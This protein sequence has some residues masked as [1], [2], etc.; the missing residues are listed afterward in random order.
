MKSIKILVIALFLAVANCHSL[1]HGA[2][3]V[4]SLDSELKHKNAHGSAQPLA[5]P[6]LSLEQRREV[7][8]QK[9]LEKHYNDMDRSK[10]VLES[11]LKKYARVPL[12]LQSAEAIIKKINEEM[13]QDYEKLE[14]YYYSAAFYPKRNSINFA[15]VQRVEDAMAAYAQTL[16]D[17][18]SKAKKDKENQQLLMMP[19]PPTKPLNPEKIDTDA[20]K[21]D[22]TEMVN[23]YYK[24]LNLKSLKYDEFCVALATQYD[25]SFENDIVALRKLFIKA[26]KK[27][28]VAEF[29]RKH[30]Y[31]MQ[32]L[33]RANHMLYCQKRAQAIQ[34][35][36]ESQELSF[37]KDDQVS[38]NPADERA[39]F[40]RTCTVLRDMQNLKDY[41][42]LAPIK[43]QQKLLT[44]VATLMPKITEIYAKMSEWDGVMTVTQDAQ[45]L[46][47]RDQN[48][49]NKAKLVKALENSL[50]LAKKY[51]NKKLITFFEEQLKPLQQDQAK[52][53]SESVTS[54]QPAQVMVDKKG[55]KLVL[56]PVLVLD[57]APNAAKSTPVSGKQKLL[58][59]PEKSGKKGAPK[60][61]SAKK[62]SSKAKNKARAK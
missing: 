12:Q 37:Q 35:Y 58:P 22:V 21:K 61:E 51:R 4:E 45:A 34:E 29:I 6:N 1:I 55:N 18:Y 50:E 38:I 5:Q 36:Y 52:Q 39:Y 25:P 57:S 60:K 49:T 31:I 27:S 54:V 23:K 8:I 9:L 46:Y 26:S 7:A 2:Q 47:T 53:L 40:E 28:D 14:D 32:D 33:Y 24:Q 13:V 62:P 11:M 41:L 10:E 19:V 42:A 44:K 59:L 56:P 43:E 16:L 3:K 20:V 17:R 15:L 30:I 48:Q